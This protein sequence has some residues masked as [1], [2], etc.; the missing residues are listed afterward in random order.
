MKKKLL[1]LLNQKKAIIDRMK[2][3]DEAN[4]QAAFD[5]AQSEL[6]NLDN[7]ITRV[8][9]IVDAEQSVPP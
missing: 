5:A 9:A 8:K 7:E 4:D 1:N 6:A 2:A 3:A